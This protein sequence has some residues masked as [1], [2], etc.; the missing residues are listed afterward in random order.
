V[1]IS[2]DAVVKAADDAAHAQFY[3]LIEV[4]SQPDRLAFDHYDLI[5]ILV[6][7]MG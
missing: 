7:K 5:K 3:P 2:E 1:D 4:I 6:Q